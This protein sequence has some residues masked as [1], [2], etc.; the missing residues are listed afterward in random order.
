[1]ESASIPQ[2]EKY[3]FSI[4]LSRCTGKHLLYF[5]YFII[6]KLKKNQLASPLVKYQTSRYFTLS[7][8]LVRKK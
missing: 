1:M 5:I 7:S 3:I 2:S 4:H 8:Q 6:L